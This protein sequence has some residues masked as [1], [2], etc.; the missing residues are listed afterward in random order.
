[1]TVDPALLQEIQTAISTVIGPNIGSFSSASDLFEAYIFSVVLSAARAEGA[2]IA[3]RDVYGRA[4][5]RLIFR[6]SPGFIYST[7]HP[8]HMPLL[9]FLERPL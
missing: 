9:P 3:F 2:S 4:A 7:V 8:I 5:Q 1:L 6:S